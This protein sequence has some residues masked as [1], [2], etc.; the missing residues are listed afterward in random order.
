LKFL[1]VFEIAVG[2]SE[3][4]GPWTAAVFNL[5]CGENGVNAMCT[6]CSHSEVKASRTHLFPS[7]LESNYILENEDGL[8][9]LA[10][11]I[12]FLKTKTVKQDFTPPRF[13]VRP[14][15]VNLI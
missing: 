11:S 6:L 3:V 12:D 14:Q 1:R 10:M 8:G 9:G 15:L 7:R 2:R 4:S 13:I 5:V